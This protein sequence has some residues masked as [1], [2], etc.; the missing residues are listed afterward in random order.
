[1]SEN[2]SLVG[3]RLLFVAPRFFGY[4]RDIGGELTRRGAHVV[5]LYDRPFDTPLM[6]AATRL[7]PNLLAK[8]AFPRY[9]QVIEQETRP[10]DIVF[11]VNGQT[12]SSRFLDE[13]RRTSPRALFILYL[14]DALR[15]RISVIPQLAKYDR[16]FGFDRSDARQ[17]GFTYRPLFFTP[18]FENERSDPSFYDISFVGTAHTDRASIVHAVDSNLSSDISRLW[19]L[20]LQA[21]WVR[22]YYACRSNK[23]RQVPLDFFR[24]EPLGKEQIAQVFHQ[25]RTILDIEHPLQRGL[26]M[27][28]FETLGAAKK[29]ITT[30][31]H[32]VE[33]D[34]YHPDNVLVVDR[35][36]IMLDQDFLARPYMPIPQAV[37]QRYSL[38]G[39]LNDI[40]A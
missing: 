28:T 27:R 24:Y 35:K 26:T 40:L 15:N 32:V 3:K 31:P 4:D 9:S 1:M 20:Y 7:A 11:V 12:V 22:S 17:Y 21:P 14:W 5:R 19:Y 8:L 2:I 16:V 25:S 33:E 37:R 38:A 39:W 36:K 30:N 10:F 34:F 23:F 13:V 6:T 29:L 18:V